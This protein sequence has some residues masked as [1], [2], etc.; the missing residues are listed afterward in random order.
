MLRSDHL[1]DIGWGAGE[2]GGKVVAE[3][4]WTDVAK[5]KKSITGQ[6]LSKLISVPK[7]IIRRKGNNKKITLRGV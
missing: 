3:G 6:Y 7:P 1:I 2:M 4:S 5:K